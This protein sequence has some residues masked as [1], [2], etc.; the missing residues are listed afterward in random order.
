L[1]DAAYGTRI[2]ID[3]F[4]DIYKLELQSLDSMNMS[5]LHSVDLVVAFE[6]YNWYAKTLG[7]FACKYR[8]RANKN[9]DFIEQ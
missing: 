2:W 5:S 7:F 3:S 4:E 9:G 6:F 1:R 8:R